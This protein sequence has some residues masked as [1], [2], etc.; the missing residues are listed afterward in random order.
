VSLGSPPAHLADWSDGE[1][2][3]AIRQGVH[4][5]GRSLLIMPSSSWHNLSDE[6]VQSIVAYLRSLPPEGS[7]TPPDRLNALGA[8]LSLISPLL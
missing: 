2:V 4:R 8:V 1:I 7:S 5:S 6:D 3:R